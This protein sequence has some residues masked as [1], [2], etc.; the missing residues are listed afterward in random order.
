[1]IV[2]LG[3]SWGVG[4]WGKNNSVTGPGIGQYLNLYGKVI[5]LSEGGCSNTDQLTYFKNLLEK[6]TP[7]QHDVFHWIVTD[8]VRCFARQNRMFDLL[9]DQPTLETAIRSTLDRFLNSVNT[10]AEQHSIKINLIGGVCDLDTVDINKYSSLIIK[11]PSWGK[12][13]DNTY[14]SSIYDAGYM[15]ELGSVVKVTRPELLDEWHLIADL[16]IK[17]DDSRRQLVD[18][19]LSNDSSHPNRHGH[20]ILSNLLYPNVKPSVNNYAET[21]ADR[22]EQ[23]DGLHVV[24]VCS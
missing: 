19:G 20:K 3:D 21:D 12:L 8:P 14:A 13:L 1:M 22:F 6:F 18:N 17:K 11:V 15:S 4:E 7:E 10:I 23:L 9:I 2:I 5:N 24:K 16:T